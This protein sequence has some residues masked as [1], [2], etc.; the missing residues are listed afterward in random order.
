[1]NKFLVLAKYV[2]SG[3]KL[4][5]LSTTEWLWKPGERTLMSGTTTE[6]IILSVMKITDE[7]YKK[8]DV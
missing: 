5:W 2:K 8:I 7:E 6:I 3:K 1:M 4:W